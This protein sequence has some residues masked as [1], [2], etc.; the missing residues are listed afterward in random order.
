MQFRTIELPRD[1][2]VSVRF[3][4][5]SFACS[6][7]DPERF[8]RENGPDGRVY[9]DW[10]AARIAEFPQGFIHAWLKDEIVGQIEMRPRGSPPI[11]YINLFYLIPTL[12]GTGLGES[13]H[14]YALSVFAG[15]LQLSVSPSNGRAIAFYRKHGW[16]D[17]GPRP[18]HAD[19][20]LME[21]IPETNL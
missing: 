19:V 6:F 5:D 15:T 13:L 12:R 10:L 9:L 20:H 11:G 7:T 21:L 4:R 17:L 18:G 14:R 16:K 3:R 1:S 8:D 2:A